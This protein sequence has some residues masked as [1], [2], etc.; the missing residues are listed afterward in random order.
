ME[1]NSLSVGGLISDESLVHDINGIL[2]ESI[3]LVSKYNT[4]K[5][6]KLPSEANLP[7]LELLL[8]NNMYSVHIMTTRLLEK[9]IDSSDKVALIEDFNS[10]YNELYFKGIKPLKSLLKFHSH[11][12]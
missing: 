1:F 10:F 8:V 11:R 6:D 4:S 12:L 3:D 9:I 2:Q 7:E 5:S